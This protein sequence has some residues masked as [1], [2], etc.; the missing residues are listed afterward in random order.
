MWLR[1]L[2]L[3]IKLSRGALSFLPT[4]STLLNDFSQDAGTQ[5]PPVEVFNED[6]R[7]FEESV[8]AAETHESLSVFKTLRIP[9][10]SCGIHLISV[11]FEDELL[12]L[13][14]VMYYVF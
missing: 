9:L 12:S 4:Y 14:W 5:A 10:V 3:V 11:L 8:Q 13:Q 1:I 7:M 2:A 6:L